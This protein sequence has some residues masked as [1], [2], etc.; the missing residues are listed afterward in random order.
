MNMRLNKDLIVFE[1]D[2]EI[3]LI[4]M[5]EN[6]FYS[7]DSIGSIIWRKIE[8]YKRIDK[9]IDYICVNSNVE[10]DTVEKDVTEFV[11]D[12]EKVGVIEIEE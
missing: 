3:L 2:K 11:Y 12:L 4:N 8:E 7:L 10:K 6:T 5:R 9:V 1:E